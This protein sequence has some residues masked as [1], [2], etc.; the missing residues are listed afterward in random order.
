MW[1]GFAWQ[2]QAQERQPPLIGSVAGKTGAVTLAAGDVQHSVGQP[3]YTNF[4]AYAAFTAAARSESRK[5]LFV[6][7]KFYMPMFGSA[8][9]YTGDG[10]IWTASTL[11]TVANWCD[12]IYAG[13]QFVVISGQGL[14]G[15]RQAVATSPDGV[16]WTQR[17]FPSSQYWSRIAYGNGVYVVTQLVIGIFGAPNTILTSPDAITWTQRTLP[18]AGYWAAVAYG[19][20]LFVAISN[21]SNF[22]IVTSP[23]GITWTQR[24]AL[25]NTASYD[26]AYANGKFL[27]VGYSSA[28]W[29]SSDGITWQ[30]VTLPKSNNYKITTGNG[31]FVVSGENQV[32]SSVDGISWNGPGNANYSSNEG[33]GDYGRKKFILPGAADN[34]NYYI[35]VVGLEIQMNTFF[36]DTGDSYCEGNDPRLSATT[37]KKKSAVGTLYDFGT[38]LTRTPRTLTLSS[39]AAVQTGSAVADC[40][41]VMPTPTASSFYLTLSQYGRDPYTVTFPGVRWPGGETPTPVVGPNGTKTMFRFVSDGTNWYGM[42]PRNA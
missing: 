29:I 27:L 40:T 14:S 10:F 28:G 2:L 38:A 23:D 41:F 31:Y 9:I 24:T 17:S 33:R 16:T 25:P 21:S 6:N 12:A 7:N 18:V 37:A 22:A 8:A 11:P 4:E 36:G 20:G 42:K 19:A 34:L 26:I 15:N 32:V 39:T 13:G 30:Q 1:T 3:T 5:I 35:T